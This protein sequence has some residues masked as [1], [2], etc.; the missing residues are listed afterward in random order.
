MA[1]VV[2]GDGAFEGPS[3]RL[4]HWGQAIARRWTL[5]R[6]V[7]VIPHVRPAERGYNAGISWYDPFARASL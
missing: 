4:A 7:S 1:D 5:D 3:D 6:W 2:Y